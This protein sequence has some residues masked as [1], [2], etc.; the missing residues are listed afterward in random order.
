MPRRARRGRRTMGDRSW[1]R[2]VRTHSHRVPG[3]VWVF[4]VRT[5]GFW[6]YIVFFIRLY[7]V[8]WHFQLIELLEIARDDDV[9][10]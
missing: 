7:D 8:R 1:I 6:V 5:F 2:S 3:D 10:L 9:Y 4:L